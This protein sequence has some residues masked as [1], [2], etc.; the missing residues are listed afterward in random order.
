MVAGKTRDHGCVV[1]EGAVAV[2]FVEIFKQQA[3]VIH[4]V[5]ALR[6]AGQERA[7][8]GADVFVEIA[9]QLRDFTAHAFELV[10]RNFRPGHALQVG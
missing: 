3:H 8:P 9:A 2:Q 10:G 5:R 4:H 1:A 7:L 6:M